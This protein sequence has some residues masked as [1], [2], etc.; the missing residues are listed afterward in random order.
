MFRGRCRE[1]D[2]ESV[3]LRKNRKEVGKRI[4]T[5]GDR[6]N[7]DAESNSLIVRSFGMKRNVL[8]YK[9]RRWRGWISP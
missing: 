9:E 4:E 6:E 8:R 3:S 1:G 2:V 7:K 5:E